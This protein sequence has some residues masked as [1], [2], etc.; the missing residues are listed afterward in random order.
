MARNVDRWHNSWQ[1]GIESN[2]ADGIRSVGTLGEV[3]HL[4]TYR[5][6]VECVDIMEKLHK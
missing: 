5:V 6:E 4:G 3:R 2:A 1:K